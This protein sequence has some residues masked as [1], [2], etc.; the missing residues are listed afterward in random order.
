MI[1]LWNVL[2]H[3]SAIHLEPHVRLAIDCPSEPKG[4]Y[5]EI[6]CIG[7]MP[8]NAFALNAVLRSLIEQINLEIDALTNLDKMDPAAMEFIGTLLIQKAAEKGFTK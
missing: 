7:E 5:T 2:H 3:G 6:G 1:T 8:I 4:I